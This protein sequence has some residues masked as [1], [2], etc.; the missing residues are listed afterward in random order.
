[1]DSTVGEWRQHP[2]GASMMGCGMAMAGA[3]KYGELVAIVG[4]IKNNLIFYI[5]RD[6]AVY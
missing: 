2:R 3:G 4:I 5:D 1:M 6:R